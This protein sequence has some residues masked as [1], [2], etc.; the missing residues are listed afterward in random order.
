MSRVRISFHSRM[1]FTNATKIF[2]IKLQ[3]RATNG[4]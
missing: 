2:V 3:R 1:I 4:R